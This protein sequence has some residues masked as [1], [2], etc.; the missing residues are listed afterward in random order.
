MLQKI[1]GRDSRTIL[2]IVVIQ[3]GYLDWVTMAKLKA[4]LKLFLEKNKQT[5]FGINLG[6][7]E[8]SQSFKFNIKN[9]LPRDF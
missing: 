3:R 6:T 1:L 9:C 4:I 7:S 2:K 8:I 5:I